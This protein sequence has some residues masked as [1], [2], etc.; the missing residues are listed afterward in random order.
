MKVTP[1]N[2]ESWNAEMARKY[3]PDA[4]HHH[5]NP[6]IRRIEETRVRTIL[7]FIRPTEGAR[8]LEV[9]CGAGN[10]LERVVGA[11]LTGIDLCDHLLEKA[12]SRL[13]ARARLIKADATS[14][15]FD[16]SYFNIVYCTEVLEH[17]LDPR[18]VIAEM[19][20]VLRSD[21]IAV[22][23][24]PNEAIIN[25]IKKVVLGN[26]VGRMLLGEKPGTYHASK[27]MDDEWHLHSFDLKLLREVTDQIF[28]IER[29]APIPFAAMPVRYVVRMIPV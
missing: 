13:G 12:N 15:P 29:V 20:R 5:P 14:L 3:D 6:A 23:S 27:K 18:A 28:R 10:V 4:Y 22:V 11:E 26:P 8:V 2:F 21:G 19:R 24:V 25:N 7:K 9:G 16:D 17:V 1:E